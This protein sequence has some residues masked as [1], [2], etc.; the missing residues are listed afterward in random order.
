MRLRDRRQFAAEDA[1]DDMQRYL[2]SA[3]CQ[4]DYQPCL[5]DAT[6]WTCQYCGQPQRTNSPDA[7][8]R[9]RRNIQGCTAIKSD[10]WPYIK[11]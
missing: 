5:Y 10:G 4:H 1:N 2:A 6:R 8:S 11:N 7:S 3:G 9:T